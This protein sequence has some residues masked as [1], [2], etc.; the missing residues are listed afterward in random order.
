MYD[1]RHAEPS[2]HTAIVHLWHQG[3]HDAHAQLV[4]EGVLEYRTL[5]CFWKWLQDSDDKLWVA[6]DNDVL[7][8]VTTNGEELMKL[9]V[10][11][12]ARG[13]GTAKALLQHGESQI[14]NNG[15]SEAKVFCIAGNSRAENFYLREGWVLNR[16]F[17]DQLWVPE[18]ATRNFAARTR[19]YRKNLISIS[20]AES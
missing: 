9:Y 1:I 2:D 12:K 10:L 6:V 5:E 14:R 11:A 15:F 7:G 16:T 18:T 13:T 4:P 19:C 8:F 20:M 17:Q 3:W